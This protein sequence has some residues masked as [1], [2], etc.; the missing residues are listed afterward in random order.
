MVPPAQSGSCGI[1]DAGVSVSA[2]SIQLVLIVMSPTT[3]NARSMA[4]SRL[5][6]S[7]SMTFRISRSGRTTTS[8]IRLSTNGRASPYGSGVT[9]LTQCDDKRGVSSGTGTMSRR[10]SPASAE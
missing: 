4:T 2:L 9:R 10:R 5:H 6:G 8:L 3:T 7:W 1:G